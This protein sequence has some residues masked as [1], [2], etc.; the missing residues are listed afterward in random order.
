MSFNKSGQNSFHA[1]SSKY[2]TVKSSAFTHT[3]MMSP[4]SSFYIPGPDEDKF[5]Q[6]YNDALKRKEVMYMFTFYI[7]QHFYSMVSDLSVAVCIITNC[8]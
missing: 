6:L 2:R 8:R 3:S 4:I 5:L 7:V 1:F